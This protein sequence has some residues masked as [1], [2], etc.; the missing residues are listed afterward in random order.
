MTF[1]R[2]SVLTITTTVLLALAVLV[3]VVGVYAQEEGRDPDTGFVPCTGTAE[4]P[5]KFEHLIILA[6]GVI[7]WA[8]YMATFIAAIAFTYAGFLYVTA[9]GNMTQ[10]AKAHTIF[11]NVAIGF[12][13]ALGAWLIVYTITSSLVNTGPDGIDTLLES[14]N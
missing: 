4:D 8:L 9:A 2:H 14:P 3:P 12:I 6:K 13:I 1:M 5:C 7:T 11:R 10:V